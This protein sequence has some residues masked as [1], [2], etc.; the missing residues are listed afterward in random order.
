MTLMWAT[1]GK[2]WGF[3]FLN[4]AG[5]ADPLPLYQQ[6]FEN[7]EL[8]TEFVRKDQGFTAARI[9]DPLGRKDHSG[10]VIPHDFVLRGEMAEGIAS[11]QDVRDI[12]WPLVEQEYAQL[13]ERP[14]H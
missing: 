14:V 10:R 8:S 7:E 11:P 1:R 5:E 4:D 6:A 9:E 2:D 12:I 13:W 3:R